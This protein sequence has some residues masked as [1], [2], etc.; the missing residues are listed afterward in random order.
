MIK[1]LAPQVRTMAE[2]QE[3][4]PG[5]H[6][7]YTPGHSAGHAACVIS[8]GGQKVI[9]FG[10][11]FHTPIQ[12]THPLWQNTFDHDHQQSTSLRRGLIDELAQ[13]GTIGF[14]IHLADMPFGRVRS[15]GGQS[16]WQPIDA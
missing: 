1:I 15:E 8:A 9:A 6:V 16:A 2:G 12:I 7:R 5:V 14:G 4:F 10:D 3:I 11:A 13:P